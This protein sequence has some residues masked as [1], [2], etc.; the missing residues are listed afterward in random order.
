MRKM[1]LLHLKSV[2]IVPFLMFGFSSIA[3]I[4]KAEKGK[5]NV[6]CALEK[7]TNEQA[8]WLDNKKSK[9]NVFISEGTEWSNTWM[10][11]TNKHDLPRVLI[12]G[13]SHVERYYQ[14]VSGKLNKK[15]Y[16]NDFFF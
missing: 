8:K 1:Q 6:V 11:A 9:K 7:P 4:P 14:P 16:K 3:I 5:N 15:A 13:D 10:V 2:F 12:I